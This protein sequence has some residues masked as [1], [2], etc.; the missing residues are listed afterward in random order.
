MERFWRF[1]SAVFHPLFAPLA[2]TVAYFM[3]SLKYNPFE[4]QKAVVLSTTIL[5]LII[6]LLFYLLFR[7][8][9]WMK[10]GALR[11]VSERKIPVYIFILLIFILEYRVIQ[12]ALI[13]EL[14]YYFAGILG[15]LFIALI[16]VYLKFKASIHLMGISGFTLFIFG[17]S[18][19]YELNI[20]FALS[21]LVLCIGLVGSSR[22][23]LK[24]H[25]GK[26]LIAGFFTGALPQLIA[27][28][29]WL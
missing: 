19:H 29:W 4:V 15:T 16:L 20:T 22:L 14:Y 18:I 9:G 1:I 12:P 10:A 25:T 21:V 6:P 28:L 8:M 27:F 3:V 11:D 2:G 23:Y 13:V 7:S 5:T 26:E 17:L 24:A